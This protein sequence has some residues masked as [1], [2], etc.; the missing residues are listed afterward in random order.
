M[1]NLSDKIENILNISNI[2]YMITSDKKEVSDS[3]KRL[4]QQFIELGLSELSNDHEDSANNLNSN[5]DSRPKAKPIEDHD[6]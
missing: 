4:R 6:F 5:G 1:T 3:M 2:D